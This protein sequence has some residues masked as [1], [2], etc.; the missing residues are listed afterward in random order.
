AFTWA[1]S[2]PDKVSCIYADNPLI[3]RE[4]LM[5]LGELA[6]RDVPLLHICGSL[7]PLSG[8]HTMPVET[9][10]QQLGGRISVMIKDGAGHHPHSL[11]DPILIADFIAR[12]L[13][14]ASRASPGFAGTRFTKSSF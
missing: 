4:S 3:T 2:K 12:S 11:R 6:Q 14:P 9:I 5:K 7:D 10:Y 1:T 13:D 8:N